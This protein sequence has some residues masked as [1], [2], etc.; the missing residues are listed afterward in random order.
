MK[1]IAGN[2]FYALTYDE[3]KNWIYWTMR[4]F[5]PSMASAPDFEKDW[6]TAQSL[7]QPG[8]S[9]YA[10][11]SKL[12][13]M[14]DDVVEAQNKRQAKL[15]EGGCRK[16]ACLLDNEVT[17]MSLNDSLEKNNMSK[18]VKYFLFI[19]SKEAEKFLLEE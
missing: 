9:I 6:D 16:V 11:L 15:M 4:G 8:F 2:Q 7:T 17:K 12:K 19:E 13:V 1:K 3:E 18:V 14:P 5:W 10:D